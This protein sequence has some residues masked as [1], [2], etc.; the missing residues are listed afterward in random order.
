[1]VDVTPMKLFNTI[2]I[3]DVYIVA[4]SHEAARAQLLA[5]IGSSANDLQPTEITATETVREGAIRKGFS[6]ERPFVALDVS[7]DDFK[8]IAGK[9]TAE[10]F[11]HIYT[12]RG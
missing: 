1:M 7:D 2:A 8:K 4:E 5:A 6:D 12:K 11:A 9:T 3:Y 10:I